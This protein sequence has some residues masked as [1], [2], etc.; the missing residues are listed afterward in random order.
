M[1]GRQEPVV[2]VR[3]PTPEDQARC[4]D[5]LRAAGYQVGPSLT[6]LAVRDADPDAV[7]E[8]LVAGGARGRVAA[9]EQIGKL[10]GYLVD[11]QG[12]L[13]GREANLRQL[14]GRVLGE[15]GPAERHA[16]KGEAELLAAGR[17]LH[18]RLLAT[19]G[20]FLPWEEFLELFCRPEG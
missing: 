3:C 15:A 19:G 1:A 2:R 11:R 4:L 14:C 16:R 13:A 6:W 7:H 12:D 18:E 5:I 17:A 8:A 10:L 20:A 9:R